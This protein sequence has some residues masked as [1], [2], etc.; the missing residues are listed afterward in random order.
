MTFRGLI[1]R[2]KPKRKDPIF[3][4]S[5]RQVSKASATLAGKSLAYTVSSNEQELPIDLT[6]ASV[7]SVP[8]N[9]QDNGTSSAAPQVAE[10]DV[11]LYV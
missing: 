8:R 3:K 10:H 1:N 5:P 7:L 6:Q 11:S 2:L 9:E 4:K